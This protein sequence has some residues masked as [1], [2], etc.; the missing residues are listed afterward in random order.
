MS[1]S[2]AS[3]ASD[4]CQT[5]RV[6][7]A[8]WQKN[9]K[10]FASHSVRKIVLR[11]LDR[12]KIA[13]VASE[14]GAIFLLDL[15]SLRSE[16]IYALPW[17]DTHPPLARISSFSIHC[18]GRY[19]LLG[20]VSGRVSIV[21]A[22]TG[23]QLYSWTTQTNVRVMKIWWDQ[24]DAL[25]VSSAN[26]LLTEWKPVVCDSHQVASITMN[27][28][29]SYTIPAKS[30]IS[31]ILI[32]DRAAKVRNIIGGD[33]HDNVYV[34]H[35]SLPPTKGNIDVIKGQSP[36]FTLKGV[37]GRSAVT[38][39]LL[40]IQKSHMCLVSGGHDGYICSYELEETS[41]S[42]GKLSVTRLGR[43]AIKGLSTIKQLCWRQS[44]GIN[45]RQELSVFGFHA[46]HAIL[47][48]LSAQYRVFTV[49]CGGWRCPH[50]LYTQADNV[51]SAIP[52][53]T[54]VFTPPTSQRQDIEV[55]IHLTLL[56]LCRKPPLFLHCSLHDQYHGRM[57]VYVAFLGTE[58]L[59]TASEDNSVLLHRRLAQDEG[60]R[61]RWR[62]AASEI[63]HT[64]SFRALTTYQRNCG[65]QD[66][67]R[68][69]CGYERREAAQDHRI[70]TLATFAIPCVSHAYR[71][72]MAC[73]SEGSIQLL[74]LDLSSR[75]FVELD[76]CR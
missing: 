14:H 59:V 11:S 54:F 75:Q 43:E 32:V 18:S 5:I 71:L 49:D 52:S 10:T 19:L 56:D 67:L 12:G 66:V 25:F 65:E 55:K 44:S 23:T 45:Q 73:K 46:S 31:T 40:D 17:T 68:H 57:T 15:H 47:H 61:P 51:T 1:S 62:R 74:V 42:T 58:R 8:L 34:F 64:S 2:D 26:G 9:T 7:C 39:L 50:A 38:S 72:V 4:L 76:E 48:N 70:L 27:P 6:P 36:A 13:F 20:E 69:V 3:L 29:A 37:H 53:R 16:L 24:H 33:G 60:K 30:C 22:T 21:E 28:V 35:H 63:A 41:N